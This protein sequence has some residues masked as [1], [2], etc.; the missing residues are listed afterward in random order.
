MHIR[1]VPYSQLNKVRRRLLHFLR[2]YG[3]KRLTHKA[4]RW[5]STLPPQPYEEGTVIA[6]A[7]DGRRLVGVI[8][9]GQ[10]GKE[11]SIIAVKPNYRQSGVGRQLVHYALE[12]LDR[13]YSRVA[14]D[15]IPSLKLCF[16]I[17]MVAFDLF[18]GVTGK[19]TLW[20]GI[21]KWDR[22]EVSSWS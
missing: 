3:D 17:G 10:Y 21:G 8:A 15:N 22:E 13:L 2:L 7:L 1:E 11:E 14:M 18:T 19:P 16:S 12:H 6:V 20:L 4:L 5:L 9:I